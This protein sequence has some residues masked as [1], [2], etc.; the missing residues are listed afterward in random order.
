LQLAGLDNVD[1][2]KGFSIDLWNSIA[3]N[4]NLKTTETIDYQ[5]VNN[6]I[7]AAASN[8]SDVGIAGVSITAERENKVDFSY[9]MFHSG[10]SILTTSS[11]KSNCNSVPEIQLN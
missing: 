8:K 7:D 11:T 3:K 9:S 6:L 1:K 5:N 10:L 2:F 4:L